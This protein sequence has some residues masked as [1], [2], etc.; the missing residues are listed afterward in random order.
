MKK[1]FHNNYNLLIAATIN[2]WIFQ[3]EI[4]TFMKIM[5]LYY[6]TSYNPERGRSNREVPNKTRNDACEDGPQFPFLM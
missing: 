5:L 1:S 3:I 6:D 2:N 4:S